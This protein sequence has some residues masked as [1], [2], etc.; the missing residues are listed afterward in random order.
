MVVLT[1]EQRREYRERGFLRESFPLSD[2]TLLPELCRDVAPFDAQRAEWEALGYARVPYLFTD[3]IERV[4]RDT[5]IRTVVET[6][7]DSDA[8]VVWGSNILRESQNGTPHWHVDLES[9]YW[10][11]VTVA[12]GL[13]GC[14]APAS[15]SFLPGTH[16]LTRAPAWCGDDTD[17][18]RVLRSARR[19][20][21]DVGAPEQFATFGDGR[22]CAFNARTWHRGSPGTSTDRLVL[23]LQYQL[24]DAPRVPLLLDYAR[25]SWSAEAAAYRA[26]PGAQPTTRVARVPL[27]ERVLGVV[28]RLRP[29]S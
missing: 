11:M 22:F 19:A 20:K 4:A 28:A 1:H 6:L 16:G 26:S 10:S 3:A 5:A 7:L 14:S 17:T 23:F 8:W 13:S 29:A 25:H 12:V 24:A 21:P 15:I 18:D 2:A 27:R 9:R